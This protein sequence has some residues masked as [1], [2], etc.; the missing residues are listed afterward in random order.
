VYQGFDMSDCKVID[1]KKIAQELLS[2]L[3]IM[4]AELKT[5]HSLVPGLAVIQVG[6]DP[7]S[8]IYVR[9]KLACANKIG[10]KA[11]PF[12]LN[13]AI[14]TDELVAI[15]ED[16]NNN[17][18]IHGILIQLPLPAQI[19]VEK[20]LN[21]V[22]PNKD[23]DGFTWNNLGKLYAGSPGIEPC[24][25]QGSMILIKNAI[26]NDLTGKKAVVL[27]RSLIVGKP[28]AAMLIRENCTVTL[29]HSHT[30]NLAEEIKTADILVSATG[31]PG[32]IRGN[33]L[34]SGACV[35]DV[36]IIRINDKLYGDVNFEEASKIAGYITP[37]PGGV[38]P[39]TIACLMNNTIKAALLNLY[40][41]TYN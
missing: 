6:N 7:G 37:V 3:E 33:W 19:N 24:T 39:M 29:A 8:N 36:G 10:V 35:I 40:K 12:N 16:L 32:L 15:I 17:M 11:F 9:N 22:D 4:L 14:S 28:M 2:N 21:S 30:K 38:G 34:K 26:G 25:P 27:G 1:G 41:K 23:V 13:N 18:E 20:T 31:I 5:N